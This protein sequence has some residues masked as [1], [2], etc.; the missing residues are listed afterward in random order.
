MNDCEYAARIGAYHDG[1]LPSAAADEMEEHLRR[2]GA[3]SAELARLRDLSRAI[4]SIAPPAIPPAVLRR[5]H[6]AIDRLSSLGVRRL[7]GAL[8]CAAAAVLVLSAAG[9]SLRSS[10]PAKAIPAAASAVT[11]EEWEPA[12]I[13]QPDAVLAATDSRELLARWIVSDL[14]RE[15]RE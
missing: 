4:G 7:A 11:I 15:A 6:V 10:A 12:V 14:S 1:E 8:A 13:A 9:L 2:C 5:T 3:C